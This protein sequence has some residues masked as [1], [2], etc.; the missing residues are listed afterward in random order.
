M[1]AGG[2]NYGQLN[3][4]SSQV[5]DKVKSVLEEKYADF[6][7]PKKRGQLI[8]EI[9]RNEFNMVEYLL[10]N[11]RL[12]IYE[13]DKEGKTVL[14]YALFN[15]CKDKII[16]KIINHRDGKKLLIKKD[17]SGKSLLDT[18]EEQRILEKNI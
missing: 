4:R 8:T 11:D 5:I 6:K 16:M 1:V 18:I 15:R 10:N 7:Y 9:K 3:I 2:S 12:S 13:T 14:H 17:K